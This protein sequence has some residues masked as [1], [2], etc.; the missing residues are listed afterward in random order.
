MRNISRIVA[1]LALLAAF[2]L[3]AGAQVVIDSS[4]TL[5]VDPREPGPIRKAAHD[6][7]RDMHT[8]FGRACA[9][10]RSPRRRR[11]P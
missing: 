3:P 1:A 10:S 4:V 7:A 5:L 2:C 11:R 8:V 9:W 6:L